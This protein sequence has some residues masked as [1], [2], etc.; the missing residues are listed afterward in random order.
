MTLEGTTA[1]VPLG[2]DPQQVQDYLTPHDGVPDYLF[3]SLWGWIAACFST[4]G[5]GNGPLFDHALHRKCERKL[6]I[7]M[8]IGD[9]FTVERAT[10][11]VCNALRPHGDIA[12]LRLVDFLISENRA[13]AN[14]LQEMLVEAGSAWEV[15]VRVGTGGLIRRV[16]DGVADAV[17]AVI[18]YPDGGRRLAEAWRAAYGISP[19]P[20]RAYALAIKAVEDA[21][22]PVVC[23]N[24]LNATLGNV[25]GDV[26]SGTWHLPHSREDPRAPSHDVLMSMLRMLW[27]GQHD[28]H[29]GMPVVAANMTQEEAETAVMNAVTLVG[30]FASG[31]VQQ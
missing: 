12:T 22:I 8:P 17:A 20:S 4:G 23:P 5:R 18:Q 24:N 9:A 16:P 31:K 21:S 11:L 19:D 14:A 3:T 6:R 30:W 10:Q 27:K 15:G 25:I 1:W 2:L 7:Q 26:D 28:R 29:G 13:S